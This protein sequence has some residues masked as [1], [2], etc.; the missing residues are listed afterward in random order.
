MEIIDE[1]ALYK[2]LNVKKRFQMRKTWK[3]IYE[4]TKYYYFN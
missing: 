3:N 1:G 2:A 4:V